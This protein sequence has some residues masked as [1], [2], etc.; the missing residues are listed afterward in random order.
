MIKSSVPPGT[1]DRINKEYTHSAG[2]SIG[3]LNRRK[4]L[5]D[6]K[7][8]NELFWVEIEKEQ[9]NLDKYIL[10]CFQIPIVKTGSKTENGKVFY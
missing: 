9:T 7:I 6:L 3:V 5:D 4:L 8:R 1:T 10:R 2:Y